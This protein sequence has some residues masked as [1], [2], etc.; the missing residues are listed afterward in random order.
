MTEQESITG[1]SVREHFSK[2]AKSL[3]ENN[4]LA[5]QTLSGSRGFAI[6]LSDEEEGK[7]TTELKK[8]AHVALS[9]VLGEMFVDTVKDQLDQEEFETEE[10]LEERKVELF[11][12][13]LRQCCGDNLIES[14]EYRLK[15]ERG[16]D[17][18]GF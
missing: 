12:Q 7:E 6:F 16:V 13:S 5:S 17:P 9:D 1:E 10:E 4:V 11:I 8:D 15:D 18:Y 2:A 3:S 14:I